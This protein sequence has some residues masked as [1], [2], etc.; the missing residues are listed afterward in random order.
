MVV[1]LELRRAWTLDLAD[2]RAS[3]AV[4]DEVCRRH[5]EPIRRY[6]GLA[7]VL[8]VLRSVAE[9]L[10]SNP[11]PD[12][13]VIRLAAWFHDIVYDPRSST[14]EHDS[15]ALARN[16]LTALGVSE[17][18]VDEVERL[19]LLTQHGAA[20]RAAGPARAPAGDAAA[21]GCGSGD[22][23][24]DPAAAVLLDADL[25]V[26]AAEPAVYEAYRHGVRSEHAHVTPD[27]WRTGRAAVLQSFLDRGHLFMTEA[28]RERE[29]VARTNLAAELAVL[30][31][32]EPP[33]R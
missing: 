32:I 19:I 2:D 23:F 7:H 5:R 30:R 29:A 24:D 11:V 14:N 13:G 10:S 17:A 33:A 22:D 27:A 4:F 1:D 26:L 16:R 9:L 28:M 21:A 25:A 12:P 31:R 3:W 6:H 18:R 8:H 15:A 20:A